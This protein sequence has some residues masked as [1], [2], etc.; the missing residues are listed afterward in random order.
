MLLPQTV[1]TWDVIV[2]G[3]GPAGLSAALVLGRSRRR[4]LV[5]DAGRHRNRSAEA[6][7]SYLSR[8]GT[9]PREFLAICRGQ[10]A[11]YDCVELRSGEVADARRHGEGFEIVLDGRLERARR[12]LLATG[13]VDHVPKLEGIERFYGRSIHHCPYCDG[14]EWRDRA[15]G[16]YGRGDA[17]GAGLALM[18]KQWSAD[19]VLCT[20]GPAEMGR[21]RREQLAK[22]VI[23]VREERIAK[24]EGSDEGRLERIVFSDGGALARDA[25]FFNTGQH[26]R[27]PLA[28]R[29]GCIFT[30]KG[31]VAVG[32]HEVQTSVPG[33]YVAGDASRDVQL[34]IV[35]AAE[36]AKAAFAINHS[37]LEEDGLAG[38]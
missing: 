25:L 4:V 11:P 13:V 20:D 15:L 6:M 16:V 2:V 34:V 30:D 3:G 18:L 36:G 27:S 38:E 32:E 10:L 12:L 31:G 37:L 29:L 8:D 23:P 28:E 19:V 22:H 21:K 24:L 5:I 35:A 14:W 9:P 7:H 1:T 26:Q 17:E 33:L